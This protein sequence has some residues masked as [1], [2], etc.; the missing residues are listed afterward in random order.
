MC[1]RINVKCFHNHF[2]SYEIEP[3]LSSQAENVNII[4]ICNFTS[5]PLHVYYINSKAF[6]RL[7]HI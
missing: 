6:I 5:P 2:Q 7:K 3:R 1:Y 4:N